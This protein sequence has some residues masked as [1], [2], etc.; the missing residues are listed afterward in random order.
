MKLRDKTLIVVG[1][2]IL[3]L[4]LI[5]YIISNF[6]FITNLSDVEDQIAYNNVGIV[7]NY[8]LKELSDLNDTSYKMS[9][10]SYFS[11]QKP[12]IINDS[13]IEQLISGYQINYVIVLNSDNKIIYAKSINPQTQA[14]QNISDDVKTYISNNQ[15]LLNLTNTNYNPQG[16]LI[17][18]NQSI[19]ISSNKIQTANN[20]SGTLILG[21][22]LDPNEINKISGNQNTTLSLIPYGNTNNF[23]NYVGINSGFS[24]NPPIWI[25]N[26]AND[27]QGISILR[28]KQGAAVLELDLDEAHN[29]FK[30][31]YMTLYYFIVSFILVGSILALIVLFYLD[32]VVLL[33]L[34]S[35]SETVRKIN[36]NNVQTKRLNVKGNDELSHLTINI[37]QMLNILTAR[38]VELENAYKSLKISREHYLTLFNSIDEGFCTIEVLFD[39]NN[40]PEDYLLLEMN[41]AFE[42]QMGLNVENGKLEHD[43]LLDHIEYSFEIYGKIALTGQ[44]KRF[45]TEPIMNKWYDVYAF[46]V[47]NYDSRQV[48]LIFNDITI[49]KKSE[50][51]LKEYQHSLEEQVKKRTEELTR[52]NSELEHF[53]YI[54]SHDLREPLRMI[55][56]FLQL[57]ERRYDNQ[58]DQDAHEYIGF[59]VDGAKRLD[60][61]I[62]D[63]LEYS[64]VTSN[65]RK[66]TPV[67]LEQILKDTLINLKVTIE[68]NNAVITHDKLP[69][70]KG[71]R[72]SLIQLFQNLI[73]NSI[74]Y[75]REETPRIHI[76]VKD[77]QT[78]YCFSLEDNGI[79]IAPD[80]LKRI[81]TIFKRLH[82]IDEYEGSGIGLAIVQKIIYQHSGKI[83]VESVEGKGSKFFFTIPKDL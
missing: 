75:R 61:M 5:L 20:T 69:I 8:I 27:V 32:N 65:D 12:N 66:F 72:K 11:A 73:S 16:V 2:T 45:L 50:K 83:W 55:T 48:A 49:F 51:K 6:L 9:Q 35:L 62:T 71:D 41:P 25:N 30:N 29:L 59:A 76:S 24:E 52:S 28:D 38:T 46:K 67:N 79:G 18:N 44:P 81:F 43:T 42:K 39:D 56:S 80:Y 68:E 10:M 13:T 26:S 74:K 47:G 53:A 64:Q 34:K 15:Q 21:Q 19:L 14:F 78:K 36:P 23:P 33:R 4:V 31:A 3:C 17:L 63:L 70:I 22:N 40:K 58:L 57:L 82:G 37:N 77:E 1:F 7:N 60:R 54:A